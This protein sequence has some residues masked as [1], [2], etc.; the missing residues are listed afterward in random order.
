[1]VYCFLTT[2]YG[3][4]GGL[5]TIGIT[6]GLAWEIPQDPRPFLRNAT[7]SFVHRRHRRDLFPKIET[8]LD[9]YGVSGRG[10]I[11]RAICES[12]ERTKGNGTFM[13]EIFHSIFS[14]P[15]FDD[16]EEDFSSVYDEA[17][18]NSCAKYKTLCP[19]S[20]LDLDFTGTSDQRKY[21]DD[22]T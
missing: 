13:E 1:M 9:K 17:H 16:T 7:M 18:H 5:F 14:L 19:T 15:L 12:R 10:C 3:T 22:N 21:S 11:L 2:A 6:L 20:I 4:P 8:F